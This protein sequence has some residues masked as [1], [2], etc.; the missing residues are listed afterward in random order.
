MMQPNSSRQFGQIVTGP[1]M[2]LARS[3]PWS[4]LCHV[5]DLTRC[6]QVIACLVAAFVRAGMPLR[7]PFALEAHGAA[8]AQQQ[9]STEQISPPLCTA[10]RWQPRLAD[11]LLDLAPD[12]GLDVNAIDHVETGVHS[13]IGTAI[14]HTNGNS[15][16]SPEFFG[17]LMRRT[18]RAVLNSGYVYV[19]RTRF[20]S[21]RADV[22][23][24]VSNVLESTYSDPTSVSG[25]QKA[26]LLIAAAENDGD[27]FDLT[28]GI[29]VP[30]NRA[31]TNSSGSMLPPVEELWPKSEFRGALDLVD[32]LHR[33]WSTPRRTHEQIKVVARLELVRA[34]LIAATDRVRSYRTAVPIATSEAFFAAGIH[35]R[36]LTSLVAGYAIFPLYDESRLLHRPSNQ[37]CLDSS[38][39]APMLPQ[40]Q[41]RPGTHYITNV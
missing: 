11:A 3:D 40:I 15:R 7:A 12:Y 27:G 19:D 35:T 26:R 41:T 22:N 25:C 33:W 29:A 18:S 6:P 17:R 36:D 20:Q 37:Q 34:D 23:L 39:H 16:V 5:V 13:A 9:T 38:P 4:E 8:D 21:T 24:L 10:V 14:G 28:S 32:R 31:E 1:L 2:V 30:Q